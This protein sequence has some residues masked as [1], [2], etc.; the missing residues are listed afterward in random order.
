MRA[1]V[2]TD[3]DTLRSVAAFRAAAWPGW[4]VWTTWHDPAHSARLAERCART[5][6]I[7]TAGSDYH[8]ER[9][10]AWAHRPGLL[11]AIPDRL[12]GPEGDDG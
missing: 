10:K 11:P 6:L 3:H 5:G 8:G 1:A 4:R 2:V 9:I 12:A 7:A